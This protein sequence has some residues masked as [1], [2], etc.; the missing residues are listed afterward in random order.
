MGADA[1]KVKGVAA[2]LQDRKTR[3]AVNRPGRRM[4]QEVAVRRREAQGL[5]RTARQPFTRMCHGEAGAIFDERM[6]DA[7]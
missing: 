2:L 1:A 6:R 4:N 5:F 3:P 7:I